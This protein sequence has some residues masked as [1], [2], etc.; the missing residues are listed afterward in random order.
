MEKRFLPI[1]LGIS[2]LVAQGSDAQNLNAQ[3]IINLGRTIREGAPQ[4]QNPSRQVQTN[5]APAPAYDRSLLRSV[6]SSLAQLGYAPGPVDGLMGRNTRI[7]IQNFERDN[8]LPETGQ[9][10]ADLLARIDAQADA[11]RTATAAPR[12]SYDCARASTAVELAICN[13]VA[14]ADQDRRIA[15]LY[16]SGLGNASNPDSIRSRQWAWIGERDSCGGSEPCISDAMIKRIAE[17]TG[18][19]AVAPAPSPSGTAT[20]SQ[21][22][23]AA[24]AAPS[25]TSSATLRADG[26]RVDP[27]GRLIFP[28]PVL[29]RMSPEYPELL[30]LI[31]VLRHAA[32]GQH[33]DE[34]VKP[35]ELGQI[36]EFAR[37]YLP[38]EDLRPYFCTEE[39]MQAGASDCESA[40]DAFGDF[41]TK[42]G[43]M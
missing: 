43:T 3:D 35:E 17:L 13:S 37:D 27:D 26:L 24:T 5:R 30:V 12:P 19:P 36:A 1:L 32:A 15:D 33:L 21:N 7:A 8:G 16:A 11:P 23:V 39:E 34:M 2:L 4:A 14:L 31:R 28:Y 41:A 25:D 42:G 38:L 9:P 10:T 6:Q 18:Q 40:D 20:A 29:G 22:T